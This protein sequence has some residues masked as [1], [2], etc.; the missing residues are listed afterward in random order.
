MTTAT[1]LIR[2]N[3]TTGGASDTAASGAGPA[4]AI[5]GSA[6]VSVGTTITLD[7]SPNLSGLLGDGSEVIYFADA[8]AGNRNFSQITAFDNTLKTVT[9]A[10]AF[11]AATKA[12]AIGGTRLSAF[13]NTSLR[14]TNNNSATADWGTGWIIEMGSGHVETVAATVTIRAGGDTTAGA[15]II[16]GVSGAAT[17]PLL[18]FSNNGNSFAFAASQTYIQF[19]NFQMQNSAIT[20]SASIAI[21]ISSS[22]NT[23]IMIRNVR[24]NGTGTG[25]QYWKAFKSTAV[26]TIIEDCEIGN[27]ANV[28]LDFI[29]VSCNV[30]NCWIHDNGSHGISFSGAINGSGNL[31]GNLITLNAGDGINIGSSGSSPTIPGYL[32]A[33]NTIDSNTGDGIEISATSTQLAGFVGL[34]VTSNLISNNGSSG[35]VYGI[36]F[37][38]SSVTDI[39]LNALDLR[40][41]GNCYYNNRTADCNLTLTLSEDYKTTGTNPS[42]TNG[43]TANS[44]Y[45]I[46]TALKAKAYPLAGSLTIGTFSNTSSYDDPGVAQ[47]Q[48]PSGSAGPSFGLAGNGPS[49]KGARD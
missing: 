44:N 47:R 1:P 48:E 6:G 20:K 11:T 34:R 3:S 12:W 37:S 39:L 29:A 8:T 40:L 23:Q 43:N 45:S 31:V 36:N 46:G 19:Q 15:C 22:T 17:Q 24:V 27:C 9:V 10:V 21:N 26:N 42:F 33:F 13:L 16:R 5:T 18:T 41:R 2:V 4:T 30:Q 28:G 14:L 35:T 25:A 32:I 38:G 49:F 7:G